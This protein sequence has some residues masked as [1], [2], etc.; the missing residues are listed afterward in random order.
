M[1][2]DP[3][4][5]RTSR[6]RF[7]QLTGTTSFVGMS[8][9]SDLTGRPANPIA[10]SHGVAVGD[11]TA[12]TAVIWARSAKPGV[13]HVEWSLQ[14]GFGE[15]SHRTTR[16]ETESDHTGTVRA[17]ELNPDSQYFYRVWATAAADAGTNK[18][19]QD[20]DFVERGRFRT[21]PSPDTGAP[22][23]LTWS[24]D[25]Y[26]HGGSPV[27]PPYPGLRSI[28]E[29]RPDCFLYLGDTIYA[30]ADTPAGNVSGVSD[31]DEA[32]R[33][34]RAKYREM[35]HPDPAVAERTHLKSL[36][37][38]TSVYPMW[39]DHEVFNNF[40]RTH[41]LLPAGREVF[42]EYWPIDDHQSVTGADPHRLYRSFRW[43]QHA[44]LFILDTRQYRDPSHVSHDERSMLGHD[45]L[46]WFKSALE[47]SNATFKIVASSTT[48]GIV[49]GDGWAQAGNG[50]ETELFDILGFLDDQS[51]RNV[52]V[53]S[54]DIHKAQ[55][56]SYD[57]NEDYVW[58][59]YEASAGPLGAPGGE[60]H[61]YYEPLN[62]TAYFDRGN[63][64]F[65]Y[66]VIKV[67][68][69]GEYLWI[70]IRYESGKIAFSKRI[71]AVSVS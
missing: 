68:E 41:S 26:G 63:N 44:E 49:S 52:L 29:T 3:G 1:A 43:G 53:L 5:D 59:F 64:F 40:D 54:G 58:E 55:V 24:G 57:P 69:S 9:C 13:L 16:T 22:F 50:Y 56:A 14:E 66:G 36:L 48:M 35:R 67:D 71:P 60:P 33:I 46:A 37:K 25:T 21:A 12:R 42:R 32:R 30:D 27:E 65:N 62:P 38:S 4:S 8:G 45:Q 39:D 7:L 31:P 28:A 70:E 11:V 18:P 51:I 19:P 10:L 20:D 6:R 15:S 23:T 47:S 17:V 61:T 2:G 34:Y